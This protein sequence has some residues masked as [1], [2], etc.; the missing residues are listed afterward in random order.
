MD[1]EKGL[2][3]KSSLINR[4][5]VEIAPRALLLAVT[6]IISVLLVSLMIAQ[7]KSAEEIA[8]ISSESMNRRAEEIRDE[9]IMQ[10]DGLTVSGADVVNFCRKNLEDYYNG[11]EAP[12]KIILKG[13][14]G[15]SRT[16]KD[17]DSIL[18]LMDSEKSEF[19]NPVS[20]WTCRVIRNKN[21]IIT[22]IIFT[23]K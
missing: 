4:N 12:F 13:V 6:V 2:I 16:Y 22:E 23:K 1:Y 19:V 15:N 17:Y 3:K 20:K 8:N 10:Y 11:E 18:V 14:S 21:G 9:D 7:F 5:S